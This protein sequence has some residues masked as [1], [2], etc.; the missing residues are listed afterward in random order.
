ML[1]SSLFIEIDKTCQK[2]KET[3]REEEIFSGFVKSLSNY[4]VK[5]PICRGQYVAKFVI[6][7]EI[8]GSSYLNG[9]KGTSVKLLPPLTL[10]KEF[11]NII[12]KNGDKVLMEDKFI[13]NHKQVFWN[14]IM[15]F[16]VLNLPFFMLDLDYSP[17]H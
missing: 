5:C 7:S 17:Y 8:E 4:T 1:D 6:Y 11:F 14:C 15:Y 9:R 3:L 10:Y 16:K 13:Q 12:T 2:C